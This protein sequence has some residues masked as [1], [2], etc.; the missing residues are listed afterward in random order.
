MAKKLIKFL[1]IISICCLIVSVILTFIAFHLGEVST[2]YT[3]IFNIVLHTINLYT[4]SLHY[5]TF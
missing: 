5:E 3:S 2:I 1:I 4:L